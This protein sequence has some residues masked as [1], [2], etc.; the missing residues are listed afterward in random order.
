[1]II[2]LPDREA[3]VNLGEKLGQT[4]APGSVIL[5][6]GDV[7]GKNHLSTGN[8]PRIGYSRAYS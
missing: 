4:L 1:M 2:D 6:K 7:G 3:T 5:L 8:W